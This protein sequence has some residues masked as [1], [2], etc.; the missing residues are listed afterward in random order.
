VGRRYAEEAWT[1]K[2]FSAGELFLHT[3][4]EKSLERI[5]LLPLAK[6]VVVLIVDAPTQANS[7]TGEAGADAFAWAGTKERV[8]GRRVIHVSS[9]G[10]FASKQTIRDQVNLR[11]VSMSLFTRSHYIK[12]LSD[13]DLKKQVCDTLQIDDPSSV[14]DEDVVDRKFFYSGINARWFYN[15]SVSEIKEECTEIIKRL[16][17]NVSS[18]GPKDP[19]AVNSAVATILG[20][21]RLINVYTSCHLAQ[22]IG[23][24]KGSY[25]SEFLRLFPFVKHTLGTGTP[26]EVF[27][28]DF[29][30]H[31]Q[32][33]HNLR[34]AQIAIMG[35][36]KADDV[37]VFLGR[38]CESDRSK[39]WCPAG[40]INILPDPPADHIAY[41]RTNLLPANVMKG[42]QWFIPKS[43]TQPFLDFM[44]LI[45]HQNGEWLLMVIQNT[46]AKTHSADLDQLKRV[47]GGLLMD[48]FVLGEKITIVYVIEDCEKSG[49]IAA[50]I[51]GSKLEVDGNEFEIEVVHSVY[52]RVAAVPK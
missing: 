52:S 17:M 46:V 50:A 11:E 19:R 37:T 45:P 24:N 15:R 34:D 23:S 39:L 33:C 9:L 18:V 16:D 5:L 35:P 51:H 7:P 27:E 8:N 6:D 42:A 25:H 22:S 2:L 47:V 28:S 30:F 29:R 3:T 41:Q 38:V 49:N 10:T 40:S 12:S 43:M 4:T 44:V 32:Q 26:G 20:D 21:C 48:G 31:L 36:D 14:S 1:V 13:P